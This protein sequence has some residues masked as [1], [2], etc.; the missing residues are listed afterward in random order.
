[1]TESYL[2]A[3]VQHRDQNPHLGGGYYVQKIRA[4]S[5]PVPDEVSRS[6]R[7]GLTHVPASE[8]VACSDVWSAKDLWERVLDELWPDIDAATCNY[9]H[10]DQVGRRPTPLY[11]LTPKALQFLMPT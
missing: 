7:R 1:M 9:Q 2:E 8:P 6:V 4:A 3:W 10:P 5:R 11:A